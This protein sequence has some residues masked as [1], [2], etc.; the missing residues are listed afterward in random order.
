MQE[1]SLMCACDSIWNVMDYTICPQ[2]FSCLP[3][4]TA[5][6][7]TERMSLITT[8]LTNTNIQSTLLKC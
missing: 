1:F 2:F 6:L 8:F 5:L 3:L 4:I 7:S